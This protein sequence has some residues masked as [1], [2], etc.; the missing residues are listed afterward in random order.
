M[1]II[2]EWPPARRKNVATTSNSNTTSKTLD[3]W[4]RSEMRLLRPK[5]P[6]SRNMQ[7]KPWSCSNNSLGSKHQAP[8]LPEEQAMIH[9][10]SLILKDIHLGPKARTD[11]P[12]TSIFHR[13]PAAKSSSTRSSLGITPLRITWIITS[14]SDSPPG[15]AG[16][17]CSYN[18]KFDH[19][20]IIFDFELQQIQILQLNFGNFRVMQKFACVQIALDSKHQALIL[21]EYHAM[22][23][24]S[25]PSMMDFHFTP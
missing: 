4:A 2:I 12:R 6:N 19:Y 21:A 23:H 7:I 25:S 11:R 5:L 1:T 15:K 24:L 14:A 13:T 16:Q 17:Q 10:S 3:C 9:L 22:I 18:F 8:I 20:N